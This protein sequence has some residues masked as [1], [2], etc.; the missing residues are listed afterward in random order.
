MTCLFKCFRSQKQYR[1][2]HVSARPTSICCQKIHNH[3]RLQEAR[4]H[5]HTHT[6]MPTAVPSSARAV[7]LMATTE[8]YLFKLE[9]CDMALSAGL[10][11]HPQHT[12]PILINHAPPP[13]P[14]PVP[15]RNSLPT[16][17]LHLHTAQ[18]ESFLCSFLPHPNLC[19]HRS[20]SPSVSPIQFTLHT[21]SG[22]GSM[23]TK[24][25]QAV[26]IPLSLESL[27][28]VFSKTAFSLKRSPQCELQRKSTPLHITV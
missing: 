19:W 22:P 28:K 3:K 21:I 16:T 18:P 1:L 26:E 4:K 9:S 20:F 15:P 13:A 14:F 10:C 27:G 2:P 25:L 7:Q 23:L 6:C 12:T 8:I 17:S 24:A 5:T 11:R